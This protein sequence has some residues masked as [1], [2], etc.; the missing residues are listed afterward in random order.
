[1][2][3]TN[4]EYGQYVNSKSKPSPLWKNLLWAFVTGGL[5]CTGGQGLLNLFQACGMSET[6]AGTAVSVTLIFLA[7]LFTGLGLFDKLAKHAGAGTLVPITGFANAM[8]AP[9]LE[10]KSEGLV[11]GVGAK[12]FVIA[13]PVLVFGIS[14]SVLYGVILQ[15]FFRG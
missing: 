8:V 12:M 9:A 2:D 3:M 10:F 13:G 1:M 7:A 5:I 15:L 6:A 14:A 11:M 4:K